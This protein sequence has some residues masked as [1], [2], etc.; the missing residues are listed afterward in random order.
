MA[1]TNPGDGGA[2]RLMQ[3]W[4]S[5]PGALKIRW[6]TDGSF[7]RCVKELSKHVGPAMVKGLC[8]N[9]HKRATGEWPAE[10]GIES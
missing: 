10:K 2:E 9:L 3:Y 8:A 6:G 1:D 4:T 7:D 5:G